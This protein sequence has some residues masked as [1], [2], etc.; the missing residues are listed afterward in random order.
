MPFLNVFSQFLGVAPEQIFFKICALCLFAFRL[1]YSLFLFYRICESHYNSNQFKDVALIYQAQREPLSLFS[2][3]SYTQT[4]LEP[5]S[6]S[7]RTIK[8]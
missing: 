3:V 5:H 4:A 7:G 2:H 1:Q 8:P 6:D